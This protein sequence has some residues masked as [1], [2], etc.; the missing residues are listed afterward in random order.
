MKRLLRPAFVVTA[1]ATVGCGAVRTNNPPD[2]IVTRNPPDPGLSPEEK[3]AFREK[4][5]IHPLDADLRLIF[6]K[7]D[8]SCY[9]QVDKSEPPPRDLMSGERW[10]EDRA[11]PCPA[12]FA[13]PE[14]AAIGDQ[15]YWRLDRTTNECSVAQAFGNPPLPPVP[16]DCPPSIKRDFPPK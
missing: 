13:E 3:A 6:R 9:V 14:F 2:P 4:H 16:R 8:G 11:L 5:G 15:E 7:A 12:E 1:I 10:V